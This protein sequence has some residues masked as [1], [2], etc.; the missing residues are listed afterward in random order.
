MSIRLSAE[1]LA[2]IARHGERAYPHE[3]CGLLLGREVDG[4]QVV[5]EIMPVDNAR[6]SEAQHNRY[7]IPP[8]EVV[9][10]ER[11]AMQNGMDVIG[12]FHSHPD[13]P[14]RPSD[15]DREHAWPWYSYLITSV[16]EGRAI[17]TTAWSLADD[18]SAFN[19]EEF[20]VIEEKK[21]VKR[22]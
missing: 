18:R 3:G 8:D 6:E 12:F 2:A 19:P 4:Y 22:G 17:K 15:F 9:K 1:H 10:G 16:Q 21:I 7:L 13:H 5:E 20:Q 11:L 14:A